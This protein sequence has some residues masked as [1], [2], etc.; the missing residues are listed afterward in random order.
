MYTHKTQKKKNEIMEQNAQRIF[1]D[2]GKKK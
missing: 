1:I 2:L